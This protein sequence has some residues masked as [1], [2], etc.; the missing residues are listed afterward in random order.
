MSA[1]AQ[2]SSSTNEQDY[3]RIAKVGAGVTARRPPAPR[4]CRHRSLHC[5]H[6]QSLFLSPVLWQ[7]GQPGRSVSPEPLELRPPDSGRRAATFLSALWIPR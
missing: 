2:L 3:E 7:P 4:K 1:R 5:G 6:A